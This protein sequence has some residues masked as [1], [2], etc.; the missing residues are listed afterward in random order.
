MA[1]VAQ[2]ES[3]PARRRL[4]KPSLRWPL[5][6]LIAAVVLFVYY[7]IDTYFRG[8]VPNALHDFIAEWLPLH[9][10]NGALIFVMAALGLNIVVGYA[11]LL[12][13]GF[14]AFWAI[15]GYT[16][17]WLMSGFFQKDDINFRFFG[18]AFTG[19]ANI[20]GVHINVWTVL[21]AAAILCAIF[22]V[23][24]GAPTLRLR[25]DYLALVTL[26]FGEIINEVFYNGDNIFGKN[27]S[28]GT[29]GINPVDSI[30]F[31]GFD[32]T[33]KLTWK[34]IGPFDLLPKFVVFVL[35]TA[36]ILFASIRIREGKLGRAW[37]AIREDELAASA[38]GV[39]LMRTK[40]SAYALG[41]IAGGFAGV[42][43]AV[44]VSGVFPQF[45]F[46]IS[47][48][49]VA[50][51]VLGG[52]GNVWGVAIGALILAWTNITMLPKVENAIVGSE[53]SRTATV[54]VMFVAVP[55]LVALGVY[56]YRQGRT[57][58]LL[59]FFLAG[60]ALIIGFVLFVSTE[61]VS[62]QFLIFGAVLV[63]MMLF[64]REGLI[65]EARTRLV[66]R[67]QGRTDAESLGADME[68]VA[69]E[70]EAMTDEAVHGGGS[71]PPAPDGD[72]G[73]HRA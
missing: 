63:L 46:S 30:R 31:F 38:M 25:S 55:L 51:V 43:F 6:F 5:G 23:I 29:Q 28:N 44:H 18:S 68:E 48:L 37:L 53:S 45:S 59:A 67:E 19:R 50:M 21:I 36:L 61:P 73:R 22:G 14:V 69:P 72:G 32:E 7:Y 11:G 1:D 54:V 9:P 16:A 34:D 41:A 12:D 64:R 35:L 20:G 57:A 27:I 24:I 42:A 70:L 52:M 40:L 66:L 2:I 71:V 10:I 4:I 39:P 56:L 49:L 15:G 17:G 62:F 60:L 26:G 8:Y 58:G 33:G 13:L 3:P 65:P 47:I